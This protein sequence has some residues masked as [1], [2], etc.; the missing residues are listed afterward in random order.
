MEGRR[1]RLIGAVSVL[2]VL[3]GALVCA[4]ATAATAAGPDA[5]VA[6]AVTP[7]GS[8][9]WTVSEGGVVAGTAG[10]PVFGRLQYGLHPVAIAG[11]RD[12][13]GYWIATA[14]GRVFA[15]GDA[16]R[17][18]DASSHPLSAPIAGMAITASGNGYWL[19]ARDGGVFTFGDAHYYGSLGGLRLNGPIVGMAASA[20][21]YWLAARDGG[22]FAFGDAPYHGSLGGRHLNG[23]VVGISATARG[24][25]LLGADGGIFTF[26]QAPFFGSLAGVPHFVATA[27]VSITNGYWIASADGEIVKLTGGI[28][29]QLVPLEA[30]MHGPHT[31]LGRVGALP[32]RW[33]PCAAPIRVGWDLAGRGFEWTLLQAVLKLQAA[34]GLRFAFVGAATADIRV[35]VRPFT[36]AWGSTD[37]DATWNAS[38]TMRYLRHAT[39]SVNA[40]RPTNVGW[41]GYGSIGPL[42]LHELGHA[43]GLNHVYASGEVMNPDAH[44][45]NYGPGDREGLWHLGARA[46]CAF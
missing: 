4:P 22:V 3:V 7:D 29:A 17:H 16:V 18:G 20:H 9:L 30:P 6:A 28:T 12:G 34:T 43:V 15:F 8:A 39:I 5:V 19:V 14:T 25:R 13:K 44:L 45:S 31:Y 37:V 40:N 42:L 35:V 27:I 24:Y 41:T 46:G 26:G 33:N 1:R 38:R 21:G 11:T 36:G 32:I 2:T 23:A 10:A